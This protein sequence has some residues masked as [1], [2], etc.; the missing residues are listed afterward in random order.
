MTKEIVGLRRYSF[1]DQKTGEVVEGYSIYLQWEDQQ[2]SGVACEQ[3]SISV[4]KLDGYVPALGDIVR[5]G[6][7][8]YNRPDFVIQVPA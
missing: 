5:V 6:Y 4:K 7:N 1:T 2:V 3:I 8:R